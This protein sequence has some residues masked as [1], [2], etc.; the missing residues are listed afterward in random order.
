MARTGLVHTADQ[1]ATRRVRTVRVR[2]V[3][4]GGSIPFLF[5]PINHCGACK[6]GTHPTS[7]TT[8]I[9][10]L[11]SNFSVPHPIS[12]Y[13]FF[14]PNYHRLHE[15]NTYFFTVVTYNR[16][17]IFNNDK[18]IKI[19]QAS[20][21]IVEERFPF[22]TLAIC[23]LPDH[24][25]TIWILPEN[26]QDY[27]LRWK[28]IKYQ[29]TKRYSAEIGPGGDR[30]PSRQK[31][32]EAAIWQRRFWEH[33]ITDDDDLSRHIDYIHFNPVKHG[34]VAELREW[35]WSSF[36][37]FVEDGYYGPEWS[38]TEKDGRKAEYGE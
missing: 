12:P 27:S 33:A 10:R 24:I 13:N 14:M 20:W 37:S 34:L 21:K 38:L 29:F 6:I 19:L 7:C 4:K 32:G 25:H 15:G 3:S 11:P 36:R 22:T 30:N 17:P 16:L 23:I 31:R 18:S 2:T 28:G 8:Q 26:D 5:A 35:Q 9:V 1:M